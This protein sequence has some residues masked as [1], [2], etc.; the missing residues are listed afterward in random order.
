MASRSILYAALAGL[1]NAMNGLITGTQIE[2]ISEKINRFAISSAIATAVAYA[3]PG[4]SLLAVVTQTGIIWALYLEINKV[5]G[6]SVKENALKFLGSA[7]MTNLVNNFGA[8][9]VS[10]V[11]AGVLAWL[12]PGVGSVAAFL[13]GTGVGYVCTYTSAVVYLKF[14]T[15]LKK[16][17][18]SMN[19][20]DSDFTKRIIDN[21]MAGMNIK[22]AIAEAREAFEEARNNGS[23]RAARRNPTCPSCG[24]PIRLD[25][26][27]CSECG[28]PVK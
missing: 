14:L 25:Q 15:S 3:I 16:E 6:L 28:T 7:I 2:Q 27:F 12:L 18:G 11:T 22:E 4:A 9:I 19:F 24:H 20:D 21:V 23:I 10:N 5:I 13:I 17:K 1:K 26:R 8:F